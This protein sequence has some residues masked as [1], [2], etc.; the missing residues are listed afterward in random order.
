MRVGEL[1]AL[2]WG[3]VDEAGMRFR[4]KLMARSCVTAGIAHRHPH[5]LR[6]R[7]A[8]VQIGRGVP[9]T[10][11]AAQLEHSKK[12]LTLDH[13]LARFDRKRGLRG[14]AG[15]VS[16]HA[17]SRKPA[18]RLMWRFPAR[19]RWRAAGKPIWLNHQVV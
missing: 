12:S 13:L 4:I 14:R 6:H 11:V 17:K 16:D 18:H 1:A 7:Y 5:D 19:K 10:Q 3:D 2:V 9:V 15:V 8:S